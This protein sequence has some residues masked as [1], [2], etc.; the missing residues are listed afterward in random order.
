MRYWSFPTISVIRRLFDPVISNSKPPLSC[1]PRE[2][3]ALDPDRGAGVQKTPAPARPQSTAP[4][5]DPTKPSSLN[6]SQ[7]PPASPQSARRLRYDPLGAMTSPRSTGSRHATA[8]RLT[9]PPSVFNTTIQFSPDAILRQTLRPARD[10]SMVSPPRRRL[11][12]RP[13]P[14]L[15]I[16]LVLFNPGMGSRPDT[17]VHLTVS[18]PVPIVAPLLT[19]TTS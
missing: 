1:H 10:A 4:A 6:P 5:H 3:P 2:A 16:I 12:H 19:P 7:T 9:R 18:P 17:P 11:T 13:L 8:V 15:P 14:C